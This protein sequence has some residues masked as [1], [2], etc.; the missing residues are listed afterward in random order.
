MTQ[1]HYSGDI[2]AIYKQWKK[3]RDRYVR[4]KRKMRMSNVSGETDES[5]W[6]LFPQMMWIDPFLDDRAT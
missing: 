4:E 1:Y 2:N 5:Q 3:V 6:D